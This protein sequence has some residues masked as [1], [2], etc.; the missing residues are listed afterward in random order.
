MVAL[1]GTILLTRSRRNPVQPGSTP[2]GGVVAGVVAAGTVG[3]VLATRG[4][5]STG[6]PCDFQT[7]C[8]GGAK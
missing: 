7:T 5:G 2:T 6:Y 8:L 3:V 1:S 4:G